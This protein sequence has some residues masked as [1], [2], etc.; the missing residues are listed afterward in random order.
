MTSI[1]RRLIST[2]SLCKNIV[3]A[4]KFWK[5]KLYIVSV[6]SVAAIPVSIFIGKSNNIVNT[7][8]KNNLQ[9]WEA[10]FAEYIKYNTEENANFIKRKQ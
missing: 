10:D 9:R 2:I 7:I 5:L 4:K 8:E 3:L 6:Y 1:T